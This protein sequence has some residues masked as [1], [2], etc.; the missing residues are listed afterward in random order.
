MYAM[1][2]CVSGSAV[3]AMSIVFASMDFF[4]AQSV[5][6]F[7]RHYPH[8]GMTGGLFSSW[9]QD[10][11][12][13]MTGQ[14]E[15]TNTY[16]DVYVAKINRCG[17]LAW[18]YAW[19]LGGNWRDGGRCIHPH[20]SGDI[21]VSGIRAEVI[22]G[23]PCKPFIG[24][25]SPSG[26]MLWAYTYYRA[27][28]V[29]SANW[30]SMEYVMEDITHNR[31]IGAGALGGTASG[32][33]GDNGFILAATPNG[34][35]IWAKVYGT[36]D[37]EFFS[38]IDTL[39]NTYVACGTYQGSWRDVWIM[40]INLQGQVL[41]SRRVG[42]SNNDSRFRHVE[43]AIA[44]SRDEI[45]I[46]TTTW[47]PAISQGSSDVLL[48]FLDTAG[49]VL[50]AYTYGGSG[51]EE[52]Y[53]VTYIDRTRVAITGKTQIGNARQ[54]FLLIADTAGNLHTARRYT[55]PTSTAFSVVRTSFGLLVSLNAK[56]GPGNN[57]Y[58][59][60]LMATDSTGYVACYLD[61]LFWT[62][63]VVTPSIH[64]VNHPVTV[65]DITATLSID[66]LTPVKTTPP[67]PDSLLCFTC[68]VDTATM[69]RTPDRQKI[70]PSDSVHVAVQASPYVCWTLHLDTMLIDTGWVHPVQLGWNTLVLTAYCGDSTAT[71]LDS[72][73]VH[74]PEG[75]VLIADTVC[76]GDTTTITI[77]STSGIPFQTNTWTVLAPGGSSLLCDTC[78]TT[79]LIMAGD[80]AVLV[81]EATDSI[82]CRFQDTV[83]IPAY[84]LPV[85]AL[86]DTV[87]CAGTPATVSISVGNAWQWQPEQ[88]VT[89]DTCP[90]T[91]ILLPAGID[92]QQF[93]GIAL[94]SQG[95]RWQDTF[96]VIVD[97]GALS[98]ALQDTAGFP[99]DTLELIGIT[100]NAAVSTQWYSP[101]GQI[102]S[103]S[104]DGSQ[105]GVLAPEPG[106]THMFIFEVV[107]ARGCITRDTVYV[108]G[109]EPPPCEN[110]VWIPNTFTPNG[111]GK[112]DV[113][114]IYAITPVIIRE[115]KIYDRW[116]KPVFEARNL[117]AGYPLFRSAKGWDGTVHG[118]PARPDVYMYYYEV[119]CGR[120]RY[121]YK[122][123]V[124]LIR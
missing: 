91:V 47:H 87:V 49:N 79:Q 69:S 92:T 48:I 62:R 46:A 7:I 13:V 42:T 28:W 67:V 68:V 39:G 77:V 63:T 6:S 29:S 1:K 35:P 89:C 94:S 74:Q 19:D 12:L 53:N 24:R 4:H 84:P 71:W 36:P 50:R 55:L 72:F 23:C 20:S 115:W 76:T 21:L 31:I 102:V 111:D 60:L 27:N 113:L 85:F 118:K 16:C 56:Y 88:Y 15:Q 10:G 5:F 17:D 83:V 123:D 51:P 58:D 43:C 65:L 108:T 54:A 97:T 101:D 61:T 109:I 106:Q 30:A 104:A 9:L 18:L 38:F 32:L 116:G 66:T 110:N 78:L 95:C 64:S 99:G 119:E 120:R 100:D 3:M 114:Y 44:P 103:V 22:S 112:N 41:W 96:F 82:G 117:P 11:S 86:P 90:A 98:I 45:A 124:T 14:F 37:L 2:K 105:I 26:T 107:N 121:F 34:T 80:S 33:V 93:V 52:A 122:G 25:I 40:R 73:Y 59:A 57:E 81:V 75:Q 8:P 70:C